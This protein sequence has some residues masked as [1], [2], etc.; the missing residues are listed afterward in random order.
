LSTVERLDAI[1]A[2]ASEGDPL[3]LVFG[4]G[5]DDAFVDVCHRM[6][7]IEEVLWESLHAA[8]F[9][10]IGFYSLRQKLYFRD[11]DSLAGTRP[12]G[13][14]PRRQAAQRRMRSGFS[15][16]LGDRIVADFRTDQTAQ[17]DV[18]AAPAGG[19]TD[20][21]SVQ[22][23]HHLMS[24]QQPPTALVFV[25]VEETLTH[26]GEVRGLA[27]FFAE[28]V[29]FKRNVPHI[30]VLVFK[31]AS[32]EE[33]HEF[34][35]G[36]RAVPA[37]TAYA[38]RQLERPARPGRIG[39]PDDPELTRL[40]HSLRISE[41]LRIGDWSELPGIARAMSA[42]SDEVSRWARRLRLLSSRGQPLSADALR[43][44]VW[45]TT[46]VP[47]P[48]GVW[49]KLERMPGLDGVKH[50]LEALRFQ[51]MVD[52]ELARQG[53]TNGAEPGSYHLVF[54]GNP[55]TG[56]TTVARLVGEMYRELG[57]LRKGHTVEASAGDL[58]DQFV[59]GTAVK[60]G[61]L[62]D[63]ALDG[64]LFIDEA[65]QLSDQQSGFGQEA[66]DTLLARMENDRAR[67]V[68]IVAGYP[69][70]M[71]EFLDAN[72]GL[73]SRFPESN[74]IE[75]A[76]YDP[77]TLTKIL[78]DRL[79][80]LG[81]RLTDELAGQIARAVA[82]LHRTRRGGFGNARAMRELADELRTNWALRVKGDISLP[83]DTE[84]LPTRLRSHL[85]VEIPDLAE[86]LGELDAMIGLRPVKDTIRDLVNQ[87]N[88]R[89]RRGK[90]AVAAPHMLFLGPPG[91]GKTTVARMIG[92]ILHSLG[93]LVSGH[94]VEV[95]RKDLVGGY[96]GQTA[97]KTGECIER[98][99]DGVLFIDEAYTL[100][101]AGDSRDFGQEA[102][103]TLN[104][105]MEN[106]RGR[107][108]V[109]AA[110]YPRPMAEFLSSN[111]GL[112]SRFTVRVEFP[113]YSDQD[114]LDILRAMAASEEYTL[115]AAAERRALAWFTA[116]RASNPDDF[117]NARAARG[118][119]A[120]MEAN[121]GARL[122]ADPSIEDLSTFGA[123]D[124]P[125]ARR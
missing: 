89:Q 79:A 116:A 94:V 96:I 18:A 98:A 2:A 55:G 41:G 120:L 124:V 11:D 123:E 14:R 73:R 97:I 114:L 53:R 35:S 69:A 90:G 115:T 23:F 36:L 5:V 4:P 88:L 101:R 8:G 3:L 60:T 76:D 9:K 67:L 105:E 19:M 78:L 87:L 38:A 51:V 32:L 80:D 119:L 7:V 111:P 108:A 113:D 54:T 81:L 48:G 92:Q 83:A 6:C 65:Y 95:G 1:Q 57:V 29:A 12:A 61:K 102:I 109:I 125:D 84:D 45:V 16:P 64:V 22:M 68:V 75:F 71:T 39:Y 103:D 21:H 26:I 59:G 49:G 63:R 10:R 30:C 66:I 107:M 42:Q 91:T 99:L 74:V 58:V 25:N 70:K 86:L 47:A 37:L 85:A 112:A 24:P 72:Q 43:A 31:R 117:G 110:G 50:H 33:V 28:R 62:I 40:I 106:R 44:N 82:G 52:T 46:A 77:P 34:L 20:E 93:L 17:P 56:K 27:E 122:A 121:L 118:L 100:S 13:V 104:Q 15:G